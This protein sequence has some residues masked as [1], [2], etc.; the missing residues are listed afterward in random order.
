MKILLG[1]IINLG[2]SFIVAHFLGK[3]RQIGFKWSIFFCLTLTPVIGFIITM[4]S[5]KY[6][7]DNPKPSLT[8][9][10]FGGFF[11]FIAAMAFWGTFDMNYSDAEKFTVNVAQLGLGC[12]G[13][14]MIQRGKG[15]RF[16]DDLVK[17]EDNNETNI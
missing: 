4:V 15:K 6:Y 13:Y 12:L 10:I 9:K 3:K 11:I 5:R 16:D 8:K 7:S 2:L 17:I 1:L 14:Y